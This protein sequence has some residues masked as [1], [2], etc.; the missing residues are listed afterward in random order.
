MSSDEPFLLRHGYF[1]GLA[2][3]AVGVI[4]VGL[5]LLWRNEGAPVR[6]QKPAAARPKPP[7]AQPKPVDLGLQAYAQELAS[8]ALRLQSPVEAHRMTAPFAYLR[9]E[10][11]YVLPATEGRLETRELRLTTE[12]RKLPTPLGG[13]GT[14]QA[15]NLV[16]TIENRTDGFIAFRVLT[17]PSGQTNCSPKALLK[18]PT[19]VL[20]PREA[21]SRTECLAGARDQLTV[22]LV[23][24]LAIPELS[25]DYL[26][27]LSPVSIGLPQRVAEG[28]TLPPGRTPCSRAPRQIIEQAYQDGTASWAD[29]MDFYGRFSCERHVFRLGYRR[30]GPA[31]EPR[32]VLSGK[33]I[34][35]SPAIP[36]DPT[37][38]PSRQR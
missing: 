13:L 9:T 19:L 10:G 23:E 30:P 21:L 28:H 8:D 36:T 31:P 6:V 2:M 5:A 27:A 22:R 7:A 20:G 12:I 35:A 15:P 32:P 1:L 3:A 14:Y 25:Y 4:A 29:V 34:S 11:S 38:T 16:L 26:L 17:D 18:Q 24:V 33:V 37:S